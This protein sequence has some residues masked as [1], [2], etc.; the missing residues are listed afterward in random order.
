M[1]NTLAENLLRFGAKNLSE[2]SKQKLAEQGAV[3]DFGQFVGKQFPLTNFAGGNNQVTFALNTAAMPGQAQAGD[4][5]VVLFS[6]ADI[7]PLSNPSRL[8]IVLNNNQTKSAAPLTLSLQKMSD[9]SPNVTSA[10][11][12]GAEKLNITSYSND[13]TVDGRYTGFKPIDRNKA[14]SMLQ[15]PANY[16]KIPMIQ[17]LVKMVPA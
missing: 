17:E 8:Q 13:V 6:V 12:Y 10:I 14:I 11:F 3:A 4:S 16:N 15:T 9:G 7:K 5:N 1:K 2:S